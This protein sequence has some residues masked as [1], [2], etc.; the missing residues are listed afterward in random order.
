MGQRDFFI[1]RKGTDGKWQKPVNL[2][3]PINTSGDE[4]HMI[5]SADGKKAYFSAD[6]EGGMGLRDIYTFDLNP[7]IQPQ[8]VTFMKGRVFNKKSDSKV[9]AKFEVIDLFTKQVMAASSS[10]PVSGEFLLSLPAGSSYALNVSAPGYLFFSENYTL[11][12]QLKP[13]DVFEVNIPL[14]PIEAGESIV[15]KNIFFATGS[16]ALEEISQTELGKLLEFLK[17]NPSLKIEIS[18]HTD[19]V[20]NEQSNLKLSQS[21]AEAVKNYLT[22]K[23]ITAD[24]LTAKGYG[25]S[26]PIAL[27]TSEEGRKQNRRTEFTVLSK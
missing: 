14:Q 12:K 17:K 18:G 8:A 13:T 21:R 26:K 23:G 27:N 25:K 24:R 19:D 11:E 22:E 2:G 5:I 1:S 9:E 4:M 16:A 6:R 10:D 7:E 20:G 15:L 3:Y